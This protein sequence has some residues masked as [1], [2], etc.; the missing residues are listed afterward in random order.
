MPRERKV[1]LGSLTVLLA[2]LGSLILYQR[3][4]NTA[5]QVEDFA[6]TPV[7][8][9]PSR[10]TGAAAPAEGTPAG[11]ETAGAEAPPSPVA[12]TRLQQPMAA[13][14]SVLAGFAYGYS[15]VFG[16]YRQHN[17]YDFEAVPGD[18]VLAAA[19]GRVV[20][21]EDDPLEGKLI[22]LDHGGGLT[23]RYGGLAKVLTGLNATVQPGSIIAQVGN[24]GMA[25][26]TTGTHLHFE[27]R[28]NGDPVDP[29]VYLQR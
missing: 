3:L 18:S 20:A 27:V 26:S 5:P 10:E 4:T 14:R 16:D 9:N 21:I 15:E 12:P 24:T 25:K 2:L 1:A 6:P 29:G 17:G 13:K 23:T 19:G 22:E 28:L 8:K 11:T 7:S